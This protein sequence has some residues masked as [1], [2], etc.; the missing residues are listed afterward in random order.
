MI[1]TGKLKEVFWNVNQL[2]TDYVELELEENL[3]T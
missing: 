1:Y 2:I 3:G